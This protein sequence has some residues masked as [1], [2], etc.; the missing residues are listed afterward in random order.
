ME[1]S[2]T[3]WHE[4]LKQL[5]VAVIIPTYNNAG[6]LAK[7]IEDVRFYATDIMV[8][9]DGC[10]DATAG[11]LSG[12][13]GLHIITHPT[14]KGKGTALKHGLCEAK[15]QGYRYA[16][17]IDSDGQH[18]ASDIPRFIEA[19]EQEPDTLFVGA[20]NLTAD[21][22]P[23]KNSFANKFSNFWFTLETGL[24]LQDTQSGYRLYPLRRM[25]V[26][27]WYY[28]AK[29]EFELEAIVFAAWGG[30]TVKNIP[31][32]VY[33]PP[34]GERV[35]HFR[36]FQDFTRISILN[37]VLVLITLLWI[38]P[39]NFCRK[40]TGANIKRFFREHITHSKESNGRI[41]AAVMLGI[42]MGIVPLW[43]Y[44]MLLT[45]LFSHLLKLNKVIAIVAANISLPPMIP[46]LLYGSYLTGC[47]VLGRPSE[48]NLGDVSFENVKSV[49]EQ[50]LVGSV[51]FAAACSV[52]A[53]I[54]TIGLL[55]T[56]RRTEKTT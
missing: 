10:T 14:N 41:T 28:T 26:E 4:R 34:E 7:V 32:H 23:G 51:I 50:Y 31:I 16:I 29:Y 19:I 33:Y 3:Y 54:I 44:Q 15:K 30:T 48:L 18:F 46:V 8:V 39:R 25:N 27:R 42:F 37:T 22:M 12:L 20:R 6:T 21:N 11:I 45:L 52:V 17:T 53:G 35:S 36:P 1:Q 49:L 56:C 13:K 9:N 55:S 43:G 38:V 24:K 5:G 2:T 47:K 40:L